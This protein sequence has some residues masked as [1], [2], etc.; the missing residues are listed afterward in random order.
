M[1]TASAADDPCMVLHL[2]SSDN[3]GESGDMTVFRL[4]E[5]K[6]W[7][8]WLQSSIEN[9]EKD[10]KESQIPAPGFQILLSSPTRGVLDETIRNPYYYLPFAREVWQQV[11]KTFRL[12]GAIVKAMW[13]NK[14][15]CGL[16]KHGGDAGAEQ[17]EFFTAVMDAASVP[18]SLSISS[19]YNTKSEL[20]V[21]VIY[22]CEY[23][24]KSRVV[25]FLERSPEVSDHPLLIP[26]LFAELQLDRL[27]KA[28]KQLNSRRDIILGKVGLKESGEDPE[29]KTDVNWQ[30]NKDLRQIVIDAAT[31]EHT[32]R[33]A[34]DKL[35][36][37]IAHAKDDTHVWTANLKF[38]VHTTRFQVRLDDIDR[39]L[40]ILM[41]QCRVV[42]EELTTAGDVFVTEFQRREALE[43]TRQAKSSI[44]IAL[45]A[46]IFLPISTLSTVFATPVFNF[47]NWWTDIN[48]QP[49]SSP[50]S[51]VST[52][53]A[54]PMN[55]SED[56]SASVISACSSASDVMY[57]GS[58]SGCKKRRRRRAKEVDTGSRPTVVEKLKASELFVMPQD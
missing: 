48:F 39:E 6:N 47:E 12:P 17:L 44:I 50:A 34:K 11:T 36:K 38:A 15:Y 32:I 40:G 24:Q 51:S 46:M 18:D 10:T 3:N 25:Y 27:E 29:G 26:G 52:G 1:S 8:S 53:V 30:V 9:G 56:T 7:D 5:R 45:V 4:K 16:S 20:S 54:E 31:T 37:I 19:T 28:V 35:S 23:A 42:A 13:D 33:S 22:N 14:T 2:S 49:S 21:A 58:G 57:V 43:A 55:T 41:A